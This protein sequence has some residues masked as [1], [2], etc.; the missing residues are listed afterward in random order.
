M[1]LPYEQLVQK[2][3]QPT[4]DKLVVGTAGF[5]FDKFPCGCTRIVR[6]G[7]ALPQVD[8]KGRIVL[9]IVVEFHPCNAHAAEF[10]GVEVE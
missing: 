1:R 7:G 3:G 10:E 8:E 6:M 9:P 2:L 4:V 5:R